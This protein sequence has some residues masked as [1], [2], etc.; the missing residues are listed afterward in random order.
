M[1]QPRPLDHV[2]IRGFKSIRSLDNFEVRAMNVLVGANGAGKSNFIEFF[3]LLREMVEE[4]LQ[5]ALQK[6]YGG[7]DACLYM[8]PRVTKCLEASMDFG[9]NRYAFALAPTADGRLTRSSSAVRTVF[10]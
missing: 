3:K 2:S 5:L 10:C 9:P 7:G 1:D 6:M 8:G 4:R